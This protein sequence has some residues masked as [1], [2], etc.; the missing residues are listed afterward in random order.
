MQPR[1]V[2]PPQTAISVKPIAGPSCSTGVD[3]TFHQINHYQIVF[4]FF[5]S[6]PL[7]LDPFNNWAQDFSSRSRTKTIHFTVTQTLYWNAQILGVELQT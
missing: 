3:N 6:Y 5:N 2:E 4:F 7:D 1:T